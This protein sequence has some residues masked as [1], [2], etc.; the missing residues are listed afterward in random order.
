MNSYKGENGHDHDHQTDK[1]DNTVHGAL[2]DKGWGKINV[3][4]PNAQYGREFPRRRAPESGAV[5]SLTVE[6]HRLAIV[7]FRVH[8]AATN[9]S[10][11]AGNFTKTAGVLIRHGATRH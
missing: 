7:P 8:R 6:S 10:L 4:T 2:R 3:C 11:C 1:V 9:I 5:E